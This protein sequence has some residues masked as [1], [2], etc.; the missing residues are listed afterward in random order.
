MRSSAVLDPC[1]CASLPPARCGTLILVDG[2]KA[3]ALGQSF[4]QL[5]KVDYTIRVRIP[6]QAASS[7][8]AAYA[9]KWDAA[10]PLLES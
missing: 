7:P 1:S 10:D 9:A 8:I 5:A 2:A 6:A 3:W 4:G